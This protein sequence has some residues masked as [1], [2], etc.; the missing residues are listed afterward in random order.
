MIFKRRACR[1]ARLRVGGLEIVFSVT[2]TTE[3][4]TRA[5]DDALPDF[6]NPVVIIIGNVK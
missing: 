3:V 6:P 4:R 1:V 5:L 2:A